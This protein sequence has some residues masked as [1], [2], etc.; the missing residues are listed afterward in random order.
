M[1]WKPPWQNQR[2]VRRAGNE[3]TPFCFKGK[4]Y[5][6]ENFFASV[7]LYPG[8]PVQHRFQED[9]FLIRELDSDRIVSIPLLN[10][11]FA[12]AIVV[13]DIVTVF[14]ADYGENRPWW[15]IKRIISI[16]SKDLITWTEP[17]EVLAAD[18]DEKL[19]NSAVVF[20][21]KR[22]VLLYE[23]DNPK[24]VPFTFLFA[25][26]TDLVHWRKIPAAIYGASRYV[27]GP[28]MYFRGGFFYLLYLEHVGD[29]YETHLTRSKDLVTWEDAPKNRP[30]VTPDRTHLTNPELF[31]GCKDINASDA[32]MIERDGK[33]LVWWN[34]GNQAGCSD[35]KCAEYKGS[36]QQLLESFFT[37]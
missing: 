12:S 22:Y 25:E 2:V 16:T 13:K 17:R 32:E 9:G 7:L 34:G 31:P 29:I 35:L 14:A 10:H 33:V 8:R 26:S 36:M 15:H 28:A 27:G 18:K 6:L 20:D 24:W 3:V 5:L 21:G 19:F 1:E 4:Y 30:F 11:Y 37:P 23:S